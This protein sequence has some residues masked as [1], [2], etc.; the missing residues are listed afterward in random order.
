[1]FGG[2]KNN[3]DQILRNQ[4]WSWYYSD[5]LNNFFFFFFSSSLSPRFC[6]FQLPS[7]N[8]NIT[9]SSQKMDR[10]SLPLIWELYIYRKG[11]QRGSLSDSNSPLSC[12][13]SSER[14]VTHWGKG[15]RIK[16]ACHGQIY[17]M[18]LLVSQ[19]TLY[20]ATSCLFCSRACP[21]DLPNQWG[22]RLAPA[23][24][25]IQK[26]SLLWFTG[27]SHTSLSQKGKTIHDLKS[28]RYTGKT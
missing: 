24:H 11:K 19:D 10:S 16:T 12:A 20:P 21:W 27:S 3:L 18:W 6:P 13:G 15:H 25:S 7:P 9:R 14:D 23:S 5:A 4:A 2:T 8:P 28:L 26:P 1:M 22:E 17:I